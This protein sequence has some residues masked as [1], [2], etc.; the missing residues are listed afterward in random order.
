MMSQIFDFDTGGSKTLLITRRSIR[1]GNHVYP[2]GNICHFGPGLRLVRPVPFKV[3]LATVLIGFMLITIGS[4]RSSIFDPNGG[5]MPTLLG[6][7]LILAAI[8]GLVWDLIR[9]KEFGLL[10]SLNSGHNVFFRT[11]DKDGVSQISQY[12]YRL[13]EQLEGDARAHVTI[14]ES[15]VVIKGTTVHGGLNTGT[16]EGAMTSHVHEM[17]APRD[18][19]EQS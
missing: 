14:N 13:F 9:R 15:K 18:G 16:V 10:V 7:L 5:L 2:T 17:N 3:L 11:R 4:I 8:G 1:V 19:Y 6:W 12:V